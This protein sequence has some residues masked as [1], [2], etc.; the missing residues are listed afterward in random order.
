MSDQ[1]GA[2]CSWLARRPV[3][4]EVAGSSPVGPATP[5]ATIHRGPSA[6]P[7]PG[8]LSRSRLTAIGYIP[9]L[10]DE[11]IENLGIVSTLGR[12]KLDTPQGEAWLQRVSEGYD[13]VIIDPY[14]RF[15]SIGSE[16][17]HEDQ[18]TIQDVIDRLK[19]TGKAIVLVHHLRKPQGTNAGAAELRG[20]GL[21]AF[22]DSILLLSKKRTGGTDRYKLRYILRHDEEPEELELTPHGPL[23]KVAEPE[24]AKVLTDDLVA[25]IAESNGPLS[26]TKLKIAVR[27]LGDAS[28]R[29]ID[30]AITLAVTEGKIHSRPM[31]GRG[32]GREYFLPGLLSTAG[33]E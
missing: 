14:Y 18:R 27:E 33:G 5:E 9:N 26:T 6:P 11:D 25:I 2:W 30:D 29:E 19:A 1:V 12:V 31:Q 20:A 28:K 32:Q 17:L 3:K 15:L 23:F 8:P 4:P 10:R 24:P 7:L 16:N 21:D 22:A 13:V